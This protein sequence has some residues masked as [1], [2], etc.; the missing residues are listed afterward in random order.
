MPVHRI[1]PDTVCAPL[2]AYS[3]AI[4]TNG[5]GRTLHIAGQIGIREDGSVATGFDEQADAAWSSIAKILNAVDMDVSNLVKVVTYLTDPDDAAR[6]AKVRH[7]YLGD[8]R[9]ASTV[10]VVKSL[11]KPSWL[12]EIEATAFKEKV[13]VLT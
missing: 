7:K 4:L 11:L 5:S 13:E 1:N 2:G 12:V 8:S 6:L 10:V 3:Q 9:P